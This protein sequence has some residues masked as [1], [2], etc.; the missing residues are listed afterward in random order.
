MTT[1]NEEVK[2]VSTHGAPN[3]PPEEAREKPV[4]KQEDKSGKPSKDALNEQ[5]N[6]AENKDKGKEPKT[7]TQEELDAIVAK[8]KEQHEEEW[9]KEYVTLGHEAGQAVVDLLKEAN[10]SPVEANAIFQKAIDSGDLS[11]VDWAGL[12]KH[13]GPAKAKLAKAGIQTYYN[14]VYAE[15]QKTVSAVYEAV[16]GEENW[17]VIR[18]WAQE[19]E[20][21]D[22]AFAAKVKEY[23]KALEVGG[24]AAIAAVKELKEAYTNSPN[25]KGLDNSKITIGSSTPEPVGGPL[26]K[27]EYFKLRS[28]AEA[29]NAPQSEIDVLVAR[30]K[31][32][33]ARERAGR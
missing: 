25:T 33:M 1:E 29:N 31:A 18:T 26:S 20:K 4:D 10:V 6:D 3:P 13:L 2:E 23:R 5:H 32:G 8:Q 7:Y 21:K 30:R 14:E 15:Q 22:A 24:F 12:E 28:A 11:K 27:A 16:G 17:T 9:S 19:A